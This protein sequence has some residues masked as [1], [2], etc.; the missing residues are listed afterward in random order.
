MIVSDRFKSYSLFTADEL[1]ES[2]LRD[3]E[4]MSDEERAVF[5]EILQDPHFE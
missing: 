5:Y 3:L 4:N 2:I 1:N